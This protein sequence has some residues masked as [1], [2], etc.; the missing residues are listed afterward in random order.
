MAFELPKLPYDFNALEPHIDTKTMEIH[1]GKHHNAYVTNLNNAIAGTD[2]ENKSI[3]ELMKVAGSNAAVR[4]NGGGHYNHSLFWTIMKPNGGG[5]PTG[6]IGAAIDAKFGSF[7]KF[8]EEFA[9]AAATRFGSGWAWLCVD[10]KK[11]LCVCSSPNQDNP[12]MDVSECPGTPI[13]G[14][15]VWEHAYYLN[16]Q[17]RRP[18][19]VSAFWNVIN[20]EEVAK[21]YAAAK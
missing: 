15:D 20:W 10:T 1:H 13:L 8:K 4:N 21:R 17:N 6:E 2:L 3:E 14:L 12:L 7:E 9:K 18:D 11:E 16:Y 19:Y 5:N